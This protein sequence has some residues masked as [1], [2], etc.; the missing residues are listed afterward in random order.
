MKLD[1]RINQ[2]TISS[3]REFIDMDNRCNNMMKNTVFVLQTGISEEQE[4]LETLKEADRALLDIEKGAKSWYLRTGMLDSFIDN[5]KKEEYLSFIE[6]WLKCKDTESY[7][8]TQLP[9][10]FE[11]NLWNITYK[12][13]FHQVVTEYM[14]QEQNESRLRN[15]MVIL[16][17]RIGE[18]F[19]KLFKN[20]KILSK[21]PKM[22]YTGCVKTNE[23]YFFR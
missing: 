5:S 7:M 6:Q 23:Y 20:T 10:E 1:V 21:F 13:A 8:D 16:L 3:L 15:F 22:I 17:F 4:L 14:E 2:I 12:Q 9:F 19:P 18:Y 11:N